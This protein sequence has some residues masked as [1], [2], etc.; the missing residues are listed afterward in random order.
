MRKKP[1]L[2][3]VFASL[4]AS[5]GYVQANEHVT[6]SESQFYVGADLD[7]AG[8]AKMSDEDASLKDTSDIGFSIVTGYEFNVDFNDLVKPSLELEYRNFGDASFS[9]LSMDSYGVF[10]NAKAKLFVLRD[11]G[12][13]YFAPMVGIG[14]VSIDMKESISKLSASESDI[15]LQAG[16]EIGTRLKNNIDL[17]VGYRAAFIDIDSVD[18]RL[19]GFYVGARYAF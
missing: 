14:H 2:L 13:I 3:L 11:Y 12:N 5:I 17:N 10:V 6:Q 1:L 15:G 16:L 18:F 19:D 7:F 9:T 4:S 8:T